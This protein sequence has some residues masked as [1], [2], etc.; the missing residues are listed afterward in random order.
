MNPNAKFALTIGVSFILGV[1][2]GGGACHL[3]Y[4]K[5]Y[6]KRFQEEVKE[7]K[8]EFRAATKKLISPISIP[9]EDSKSVSTAKMGQYM[10]EEVTDGI[11]DASKKLN[12][13]YGQVVTRYNTITKPDLDALAAKYQDD[14]FSEH[15][16]E[17]ESPE[18]DDVIEVVEEETERVDPKDLKN[19]VYI[20]EAHTRYLIDYETFDETNLGYD[21]LSFTYWLENEQLLDEMDE[22]FADPDDILC[23]LDPAELHLDRFYIR[24]DD[25]GVDYEISVY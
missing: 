17:R 14:E 16:A 22:P 12:I 6:E 7:V 2:V 24:N 23:G 19:V 25:A 13:D 15:L 8:E 10:V 18:E 9:K 20:N 3:Y 4:K 11:K 5:I 1:A 21:K